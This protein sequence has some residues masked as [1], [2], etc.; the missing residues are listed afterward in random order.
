[1]FIKAATKQTPK[2]TTTVFRGHQ[3]RTV[4]TDNAEGNKSFSGD[5]LLA[6]EIFKWTIFAVKLFCDLAWSEDKQ[7]AILSM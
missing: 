1:M 7:A 6:G 3:T 4:F 5:W 2:T